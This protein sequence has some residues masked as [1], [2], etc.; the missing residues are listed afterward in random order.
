MKYSPKG[1]YNSNKYFQASNYIAEKSRQTSTDTSSIC[2][3]KAPTALSEDLF[4][5][6]SFYFIESTNNL[7]AKKRHSPKFLSSS[8]I[9]LYTQANGTFRLKPNSDKSSLLENMR[10]TK[11]FVNDMPSYVP[12]FS[13]FWKDLQSIKNT[14]PQLRSKVSFNYFS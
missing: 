3:T 2:H 10:T 8:P 5:N 9:P 4:G 7:N 14:D 6:G 11:L 13:R 12:S 1:F